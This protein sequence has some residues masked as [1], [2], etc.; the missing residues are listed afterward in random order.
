MRWLPLLLAPS[1][2]GCS[3]IYNPGDLPFRDDAG[4]DSRVDAEIVLDADPSR[5]EITRVA[6]ARLIEGVG[7]GGSRRTLI[8]VHGT[9]IVSG[10]RI[11]IT[12][13]AGETIVPLIT[14]DDALTQV[15]DNGF[16]VAAPI[17]IDVHT[18]LAHGVPLR[19]DV[20]VTQPDGM[21]GMVT[22]TLTMLDDPAPDTP[23]LVLEGRDELEVADAT[24]P[25]GVHEFSRVNITGT[26]NP[27]TAT[28]PLVVRATSTLTVGGLV[29]VNASGLNPGPGGALGG[30][31]GAGGLLDGDPGKPGEGISGGVSGGGGG[32]FG[33]A[34]TA[35]PTGAGGAASVLASIPDFRLHRG[36]GGAGG[37][38][39][40]LGAAGGK[41]GAS[42]GVV[43]LTAGGAVRVAMLQAIG[44]NGATAQNDGGGG[45]G[46]A[47]LLR[48][49]SVA[50]SGGITLTGGQG[51][52][53]AGE[54]GLGRARIDVPVTA[55]IANA[56]PH[57]RGPVFAPDTPLIVR[58][59]TPSL[60]VIG[61]PMSQYTYFFTNED[62][63]DTEGPFSDSIAPN[64]TGMVTLMPLFRGFNTLCLQVDGAVF[65][66]ART[67]ARNCIDIVYLF[68]LP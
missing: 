13:H 4:P 56:G 59:E 48:G 37:D 40:A 10:A 36:S 45:S 64:G 8:T 68:T 33:T 58:D 20:S 9:Q 35:G 25:A 65:G 61:Q 26:L 49:S 47:V 30:P 57:F 27:T 63:S 50:I 3:L 21:G 34:G 32:G 67:E 29:Q 42:G 16:L 38:G 18:A 15:A 6:P 7:S 2:L 19:L 41:G 62:G 14:V 54:G 28:E 66:D 46:G 51:P 43:E 24:L 12:G 17:E 52:Q 39:V 60:M 22:Q 31:G 5:L 23:V 11:A 55:A 53:T 1:A 44:G